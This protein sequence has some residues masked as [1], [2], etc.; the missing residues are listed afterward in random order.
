M[1]KTWN[2]KRFDRAPKTAHME[3][4]DSPR[5]FSRCF[6]HDGHNKRERG[7]C[8][9][10]SEKCHGSTYC[11]M[12]KEK[13]EFAPNIISNET[14]TKDTKQGKNKDARIVMY[15]KVGA[16]V[17]NRRIKD[18]GEVVE[19]EYPKVRIIYDSGQEVRYHIEKAIEV[20]ELI[21]IR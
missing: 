13:E 11:G 3:E 2:M 20:G 17:W 8:R 6:Y 16:L 19:V 5:H 12:Y 1:S 4:W 9:C 7:H 10:F 15:I 21:L 18:V 14:V